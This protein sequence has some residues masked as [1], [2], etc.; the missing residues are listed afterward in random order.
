MNVTNQ[1]NFNTFKSYPPLSGLSFSSLKYTK[2]G[3]YMIG[4]MNNSYVYI[5][6]ASNGNLLNY[7]F[8][9]GGFNVQRIAWLNTGNNVLLTSNGNIY[10]FS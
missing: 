3:L 9:T 5:Y 8:P 4:A 2:D 1:A 6:N 7:N 10:L